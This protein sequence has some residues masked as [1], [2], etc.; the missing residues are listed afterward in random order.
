MKKPTNKLLY[1]VGIILLLAISA[2][3]IATP[4]IS[5][6]DPAWNIPTYAYLSASPRTVG[7]G[8]TTLLVMWLNTIPPTAGGTG[9]D[10]WRGFTI[11]VTAPDG[12]KSQLGPFESGSVG[13]TY[14]AFNPT[15]VGTYTL[16]FSWLGQTLA[17]GVNGNPMGMSYVGD[18]FEP[19]TSDPI[20]LVVT[21]APTQ[22]WQEPPVTSGYWS[23]PLNAQNREWSVLASNWLGGSW[24]VSNFQRWGR[25]PNSPHIVWTQPIAEQPG[26]SS[27]HPGGI[28]DA[29]W[30][31]IPYNTDDYQ[32]PWSTPILMNGIIYY[33]S[34]GDAMSPK[35]GYY[36]MDLRTGEQL[37]YN[38]GTL[39][40]V[41]ISNPSFGE[42]PA[43]AQSFPRLSFGQLFHY[44]S[45]NGQGIVAYLWMTQGST[46]YMLDP[47]NGNLMMTLTNVP[48]GI[49]IT[50][51]D[52]S[53]LRY[54]Y[55][56]GTGAVTAW[57]LT[58]AIPF[59]APGTGTSANQWRPRIG[60]VI[61]AV[62]DTSWAT[63]PLPGNGTN[64]AWTAADTF[65]SA[66][67]L[68]VTIQKGLPW[69]SAPSYSMNFGTT[70]I[71]QDSNRVPQMIFSWNNPTAQG[72]VTGG[73]GTF[74]AWAA[75]ID[76]GVDGYTGGPAGA[77]GAQ[78]NTNLGCGVTVLWS[79]EYTPPTTTGN[80]T[81]INGAI[82]YDNR[83][84]TIYG[85]ETRQFY[86]YSLDTGEFLWGPTEAQGGWDM[87]GM[88][89]TAAYGNLYSCGY[90]G[91][92][93]CY[94]IKTGTQKWTYE[95]TNVGGESPYG[96]Y[97]ISILSIAD[98][99]VF[100]GSSEHSPTK[101]L[102]RGSYLRAIDAVNGHE[103]WKIETWVDGLAIADGYAV[104]SN[105]YSNT[106]QAFG[107]GPS[108][109]TVTASPKVAAVG[110]PVLIEGTVT[111][112]SPGALGTPA[113]ADGN[114]QK[115]MEYLYMQQVIPGDA[116]GVPVKLT[117][118]SESGAISDVGTVTSDMSGMFK[119]MW[120]PPA[121]GAYTIIATFE[122]TNSYDSSYA[123]TAVGVGSSTPGAATPTPTT[124]TIANAL[125]AEIFYAFAIV[126]IVMIVIVAVLVL[127]KK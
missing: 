45:L 93:H 121:S 101:P 41:V 127:R 108:A 117:A 85:K 125:S 38:N 97:P 71:L 36:A 84:F 66:Y 19:A 32:S 98:G 81:W 47:D 1:S 26:V 59:G 52:G 9:G 79:K 2:V 75:T 91:I 73:N 21:S 3:A 62:N 22:P 112:Q 34:P 87:Y 109:T 56:P 74:R 11:D 110:S 102:W 35:Y 67:S 78:S 20:S 83:V 5:A 29:Q 25:A 94:D 17:A 51:Q 37:W 90:D 43:L 60:A 49:G 42:G 63:Y 72:D 54:N 64:G 48:G 122:G 104:C 33:N 119:T 57:N 40:N 13:I 23:R 126:I 44:N 116:Q 53:I 100:L 16:V 39:N 86:G 95:A 27:G 80:I 10:R 120:T 114:M 6:H 82:D 46:W 107:K 123:E 99:K 124:N 111:D 92:L 7:V 15:Q 55:N 58:Q 76:Y 18:Y 118:I 89:G 69:V 106:I 88:A 105:H 65:H 50:D 96:N 115:W 113:I 77:V 28:A 30:P 61:N 70:Q 68:N 4:T 12:S 24:L 8:E 103:A 14:T 31:G